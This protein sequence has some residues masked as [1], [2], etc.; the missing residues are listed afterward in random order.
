[1][2]YLPKLSVTQSFGMAHLRTN[3]TPARFVPPKSCRRMPAGLW[4]SPC[5]RLL[6]GS[7]IPHALSPPAR[8]CVRLPSLPLSRQDS[9]SLVHSFRR[10]WEEAWREPGQKHPGD[11]RQVQRPVQTGPGTSCYGH[12]AALGSNLFDKQPS[13]MEERR[14]KRRSGR[15]VYKREAKAEPRGWTPLL[16]D[17]PPPA[18]MAASALGS[19]SP[20][21]EGR[22]FPKWVP[23][24]STERPPS[25]LGAP[26]C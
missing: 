21:M 11:G 22:G 25:S 14:G 10:D 23:S 18:V 8:H 1:M 17:R 15:D 13:F 24:G 2:S 26:G 5:R 16:V 3:G 20:S 19:S 7:L 12:A 6:R 4:R 9:R